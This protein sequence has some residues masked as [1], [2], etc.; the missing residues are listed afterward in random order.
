VVR[1]RGLREPGEWIR[2]IPLKSYI[3]PLKIIP[4]KTTLKY[5][6]IGFYDEGR[7]RAQ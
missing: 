1:V 7:K 2:K 5:K 3:F 6:N 4:C